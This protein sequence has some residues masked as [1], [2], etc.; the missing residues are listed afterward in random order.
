[1]AEQYDVV[2]LGGGTGGYVAAIRA[3]QLGLSVAVVEK[4]KVGGT[5]LHRG[6]IPSKALLKSADVMATVQ[7]SKDFGIQVEGSVSLDFAGVMERKQKIINNL[8][9]GVQSLLKKH[10]IP[11]IEGIG[12]VMG[13]SIFSPMAGAVSVERAN[14]ESEIITPRNVIIA[15][16][17]RPRTLPGL[18]VDGQYVLTSDEALDMETLPKSMIIVGAG[19]I[20]VEW[21]SLLSDFGVEVTLVEFADRILAVEDEDVSAEVAKL[22]GR[23][24]AKVKILTST[25]VMGET[26][27]VNG[28]T[29]SVQ[30]KVNVGTD[31]E[32]VETLTAEKILVSVGRQAN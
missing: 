30:A 14:G 8:H 29:V 18:T 15:T 4:D 2:I 31:K 21:A 9:K 3:A 32:A 1:M 22:L 19:A 17:S 16:G 5:C 10:N 20:G 28:D 24:K 27:Q 25:A 12:R 11:V 26:F 13:P 7:K 23:R 6:C